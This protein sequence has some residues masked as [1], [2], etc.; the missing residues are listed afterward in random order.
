M[1]MNAIRILAALL[2][3]ASVAC[4]DPPPP[5]EPEPEWLYEQ[6][7]APQPVIVLDPLL[8]PTD[9]RLWLPALSIGSSLPNAVSIQPTGQQQVTVY[10]IGASVEI[11]GV[12]VADGGQITVFF[13][14]G[15]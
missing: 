9:G 6:T 3:L 2:L 14:A 4:D 12:Q 15:G 13:P 10:P 8:H 5:S 7:A 1:T 11:E